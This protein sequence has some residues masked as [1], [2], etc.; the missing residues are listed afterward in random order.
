MRG[1]AAATPVLVALLAVRAARADDAPPRPY[2]HALEVGTYYGI[3]R[4]LAPKVA[5]GTERSSHNGGSTLA[6]DLT[7]RTPYFLS[8]FIDLSYVPLYSGESNV[9]LG[10]GLGVAHAVSS[11]HAFGVVAGPG[12]DVWRLRA[13]AGIGAYDVIVHAAARGETAHAAELDLGYAFSIGG[14]LLKRD[15][16][17]IGLEGRL[18]VIA[19]ASMTAGSLGL[20]IGFDPVRF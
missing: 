2:R 19:D 18:L 11:V 15:R 12:F 9:D 7:Y 4:T 14:F 17:R 16:F 8:P 13:R 5:H 10:G 20:T 3:A 1:L 6:L